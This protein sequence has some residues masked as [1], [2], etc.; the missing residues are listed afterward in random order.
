MFESLVANV[1]SSRL[2]QFVKRIDTEK[3]KL[4][5]WRGQ[6]FYFVLNMT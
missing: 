6:V 3:L 4:G 5:V 1:L 2:T